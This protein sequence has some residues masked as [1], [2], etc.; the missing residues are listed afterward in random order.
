MRCLMGQAVCKESSLL[1]KELAVMDTPKI[2]ESE[3]R[4]CLSMWERAPVTASELTFGGWE[5]VW[6]YVSIT[7]GNTLIDLTINP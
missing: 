6:Y 3:Y 2:F 7:A 4:F 1:D 5:S